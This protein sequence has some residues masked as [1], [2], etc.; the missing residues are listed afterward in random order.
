MVYSN[1]VILLGPSFYLQILEQVSP[2]PDEVHCAGAL[3]C[4]ER[5]RSGKY[6]PG[7]SA[8]PFS[9]HDVYAALDGLRLILTSN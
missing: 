2:D 4:P 8:K 6:L 1:Y 5:S 7:K 3:S 9:M